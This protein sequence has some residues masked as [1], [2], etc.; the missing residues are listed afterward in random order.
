LICTL[1]TFKVD[2]PEEKKKE[3][4]MYV[5]VREKEIVRERERERERESIPALKAA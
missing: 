1:L 2:C 5:C 4:K 3:E